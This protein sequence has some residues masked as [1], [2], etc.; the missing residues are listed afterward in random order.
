MTNSIRKIESEQPYNLPKL[1]QKLLEN[2]PENGSN[3]GNIEASDASSEVARHDQYSFDYLRNQID[4]DLTYEM[5][6]RYDPANPRSTSHA[7]RIEY[8]IETRQTSEMQDYLDFVTSS[9]Y[10]ENQQPL[11]E[12]EKS[13]LLA[14]AAKGMLCEA[15][16]YRTANDEANQEN[17]LEKARKYLREAAESLKSYDNAHGGASSESAHK[18]DQIQNFIDEISREIERS[19]LKIKNEKAKDELNERIRLA[20]LRE[21]EDDLMDAGRLPRLRSVGGRDDQAADNRLKD[22][23]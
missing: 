20:E 2:L 8:L 6:D 21:I 14:T 19:S 22:V 13:I 4:Q 12:A 18:T 7:D 5:V 9:E 10:S 11:N 1:E 16:I 17:L 15:D 3:N 23:A